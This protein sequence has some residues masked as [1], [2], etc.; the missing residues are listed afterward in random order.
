MEECEDAFQYSIENGRYAIADGAT[1]SAFSDR[2]AQSLVK[3]FV[4]DPPFGLPPS[5]DALQI[6]LLPLQ[7]EWHAGINWAALPWYAEEKA[8]KGGFAALVGVEFGG[9]ETIWQRVFSRSMPTDE[10]IW[11]AFAIGDSCLFQARDN[12]LLCTFP[13]DKAEQFNSRPILVATNMINNSSALKDI[14]GAE[15][16]C[17][18]GDCFFLATDALAKWILSQ[19]EAGKAPWP[20]LLGL[21]TENDFAEFVNVQRQNQSLKNDDTTLVIMEWTSPKTQKYLPPGKPS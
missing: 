4:A 3:Q 21:R 8:K 19:H 1:E 14:R 13:L 2:W 18:A 7:E 12:Q 15:G 20:T 11:H 6:W 17:R 10:L 9:S 5:E 16:T